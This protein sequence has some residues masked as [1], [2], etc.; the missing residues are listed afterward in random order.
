MDQSSWP[1]IPHQYSHLNAMLAE[2][3]VTEILSEWSFFSL[4]LEDF[5]HSM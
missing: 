1:E 3:A 4:T 2:P 5:L